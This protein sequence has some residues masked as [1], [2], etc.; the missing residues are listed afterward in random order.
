MVIITSVKA[1]AFYIAPRFKSLNGASN[2]QITC[3]NIYYYT[4]LYQLSA[5]NISEAITTTTSMKFQVFICSIV[6]LHNV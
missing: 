2:K 6:L 4:V 5:K 3:C 1:I